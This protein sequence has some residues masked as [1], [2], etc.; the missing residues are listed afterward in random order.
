MY[1]MAF[2]ILHDVGTKSKGHSHHCIHVFILTFLV[3]NIYIILNIYLIRTLIGNNLYP[4]L[5]AP[6]R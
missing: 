2:V 6:L 1:K 3:H 5:D 4:F